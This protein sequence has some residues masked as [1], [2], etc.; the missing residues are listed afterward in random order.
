MSCPKNIV[1]RKFLW[2]KYTEEGP[3]D[4][5][6]TRIGKF[7]SCNDDFEVMFECKACGTRKER[8]FIEMEDLIRDG[9]LPATL[10]AV[11]PYNPYYPET[12]TSIKTTISV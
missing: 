10:N 3:H 5:Y 6:I 9:I 11:G 8:K 2:N 12:K 1:Q 4:W 7:M